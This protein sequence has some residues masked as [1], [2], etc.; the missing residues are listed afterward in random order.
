[1]KAKIDKIKVDKINIDKIN[2]L[3]N[4]NSNLNLILN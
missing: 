3:F 2:N 1:M 4:S